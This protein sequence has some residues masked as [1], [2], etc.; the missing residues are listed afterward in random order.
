[1][2]GIGRRSGPHLPIFYQPD[3]RL[4]LSGCREGAGL[5]YGLGNLPGG[6]EGASDLRGKSWTSPRACQ[7]PRKE[8]LGICYL[9]VSPEGLTT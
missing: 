4:G 7:F 8:A 1:M 6:R 5:I 2:E 3:R 9:N